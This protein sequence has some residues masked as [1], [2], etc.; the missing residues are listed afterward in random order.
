M[1]WRKLHVVKLHLFLSSYIIR[2][3]QIKEDKVDGHVACIGE[4]R[5][6]YGVDFG[7]HA[8]MRTLGRPRCRWGIR[9]GNLNGIRLNGLN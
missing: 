7:K 5:N 8:G 9:S 3:A 4:K 2:G 1:K 6:V